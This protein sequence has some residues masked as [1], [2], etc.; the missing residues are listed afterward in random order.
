VGKKAWF[1]I[2]F[3]VVGVNLVRPQSCSAANFAD[4]LR[5]RS[6]QRSYAI[7]SSEATISGDHIV[8]IEFLSRVQWHLFPF[9]IV[10]GNTNLRSIYEF[11][12]ITVIRVRPSE[13]KDRHLEVGHRPNN[14]KSKTLQS[15]D[16]SPPAAEAEAE[17]HQQHKLRQTMDA[18]TICAGAC[19]GA[20]ARNAISNKLASSSPYNVLVVNVAGS[21]FLGGLMGIPQQN[22]L[23]RP[24]PT[25]IVLSNRMQ[26]LLG[27]GF[28]GS[29]T[30]M[31]SYAVGVVELVESARYARAGV[32]LLATNFGSVGA[33]S[34]GYALMKNVFLKK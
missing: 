4:T 1:C 15:R 30:T 32:Y 8:L 3:I 31:S 2:W 7:E 16:T 21:L 23:P 12:N 25:S 22:S 33:A 9:W 27:V 17:P 11:Y 20:L 26:L 19:G 28:A 6:L 14:N 10:F 29:F 5:P 13:R 18:L 34:I 24:P